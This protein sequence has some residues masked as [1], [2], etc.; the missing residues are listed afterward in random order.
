MVSNTIA[1]LNK[2]SESIG[3]IYE[4]GLDAD[5]W[6]F[7]LKALSEELGADKA[8]MIYLNPREFFISFACGYGFDP[9]SFDIGAG[10]FRRYLFD[11][12]VAQFG[13]SHLDEVFSDSRVI[14]KEV[15]HNSGMQKYIRGPANM[16]HML[17]V[18]LQDSSEDWSGF[19]F[20]RGKEQDPFDGQDEQLLSTFTDHLKRSSLIQKSIAGTTQL[21]ALQNAVLDRVDTGILILDDLH[22]VLVCNKHAKKII[23]YSD[24]LKLFRNRIVCNSSQENAMLH[25]AIDGALSQNKEPKERKR[26]AVRLRG[27][28]RLKNLIAVTTPVQFN[29]F[30]E[31]LEYEH[32]PKAHYTAKIPYKKNVLVT[33]CDPNDVSLDSESI[34]QKLFGLTPA[35]AALADCLADD[36]TLTDA[37]KKLG[38]SVGTA[39]IQLQSIFGKTDTNRQTSLIKL[40]SSIPI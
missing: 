22:D 18:F 15:L 12:P 31:K 24:V 8:Q 29:N 14:K 33:I 26:I 39:R 4:A 19:C 6:P 20:F 9:Y 25:E 3:H 1:G 23:G 28:D 40:I 17:T 38:R 27:V 2:F 30:E 35:E 11:D 37:S 5:K 36:L 13:M 16:E 10:K 21:E 32:L 7:A 34:L